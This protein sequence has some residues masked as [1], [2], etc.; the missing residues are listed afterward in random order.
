M[1]PRIAA[2]DG[3]T[4]FHHESLRGARYARFFD[5]LIYMPDFGAADL[6]D[7][8]ALIVTCRTNADFLVPHRDAVRAFLESGGTLVACGETDVHL[9]LDGICWTPTLTNYWWWLQERADSGLRLAAPAHSLF[10]RMTLAD[11]TWHFHGYFTPPPGA[12]SLIDLAGG[13]SI[14]YDDCTSFAGR[15][16]VTSLDPF[17]H[18]GSHFMPAT[19]R[20]LDAFLPWLTAELEAAHGH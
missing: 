9:W 20:F 14:L 3:G 13:G 12:Q 10:R 1:T 19:T 17:Y 6:T 15:A 18:H 11:A 16:I 2:T 5:R 8:D 4:Y 7:I